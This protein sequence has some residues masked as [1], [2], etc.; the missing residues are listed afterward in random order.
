MADA[1]I[2]GATGLV[3][4][5]ALAALLA[6]DSF[7]RVFAFVR[8]STGVVHPR[9]IERVV[10]FERLEQ[11]VTAVSG[12]VAICALGSTIKQ[13]GSQEQFRHID[14]DYVLTFARA[15]LAGGVRHF[16][17]VTALGADAR[18]RVFYNRVK[19]E[20]EE[21]LAAMPFA[22]LTIVRPSLLLGERTEVRLGER[23]LGP[24]SR[25]L[26]RSV[27]GIDASTVG[28]ALVRLARE[29][30]HGRRVVLSKELHELGA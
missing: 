16:L 12:D 4:R 5:E 2:V 20:V 27:A 3:G 23:L 1:W 11:D 13:A 30:A 17:V 28:R 21:A 6:D 25:L 7:G 19:G 9:L 14:R 10:D 22:A 8:R 26:P 18:S 29:P 15:A 24:F